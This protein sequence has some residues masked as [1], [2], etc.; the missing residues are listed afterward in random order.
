MKLSPRK[1]V[2]QV[3]NKSNLEQL[4]PPNILIGGGSELNEFEGSTFN[5]NNIGSCRS[6]KRGNNES[7]EGTQHR[8]SSNAEPEGFVFEK[9]LVTPKERNFKF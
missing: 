5:D 6:L 1:N 2:K 7:F 9:D 8:T 4:S 3:Q